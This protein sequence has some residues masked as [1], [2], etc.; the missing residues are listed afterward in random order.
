[1]FPYRSSQH[2]Q[3]TGYQY[4]TTSATI[5]WNTNNP[6]SSSV[7]SQVSYGTTTGYGSSVSDTSLGLHSVN[8][9]S[10]SAGTKYYYQIQSSISGIPTATYSNYFTTASLP[11]NPIPSLTNV[12]LVSIPNPSDVGQTVG[13]G[14]AVIATKLTV[15][16]PGQLHTRM[17]V[18]YWVPVH[19]MDWV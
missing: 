11:L 9:S 5:S 8:L 16:L 1:M 18:P 4:Q 7:T 15:F 10:L 14:V 3:C 17:A 6:S 12:I 2:I 13:F 19:S